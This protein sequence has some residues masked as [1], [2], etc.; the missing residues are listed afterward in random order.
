I[1]GPGGAKV[2]LD[3][4]FF[5]PGLDG[6]GSGLVLSLTSVSYNYDATGTC[7][8]HK[9]N[10]NYGPLSAAP[11]SISMLGSTPMMRIQVLRERTAGSAIDV[12]A[13]EV[14][15]DSTQPCSGTMKALRSYNFNYQND[16]DTGQ[17]QLKQVTMIGREGS[18]DRSTSLPV[19]TY[20]Y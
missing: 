18:A 15:T 20:S 14:A 13:R 16:A 3:Y 5:A 1:L 9:I 6:G 19:A 8:K 4:G 7:P 12:M 10:L 11:L 2:H 17:L